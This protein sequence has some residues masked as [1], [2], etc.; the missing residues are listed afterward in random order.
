[1]FLI[2]TVVLNTTR[3]QNL[4]GITLFEFIFLDFQVF[5]RV[6]KRNISLKYEEKKERRLLSYLIA[7][8]SLRFILDT[9]LH[10]VRQIGLITLICL[11]TLSS[12]ILTDK[13]LYTHLSKIIKGLKKD[14]G[15]TFTRFRGVQKDRSIEKTKKIEE[16][17]TEK[18]E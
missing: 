11:L 17:L 2:V 14:W 9:S 12:T 16:K 5:Y 4:K 8:W 18:T 7:V 6:G 1:M 10:Q 3:W 13:L 15:T